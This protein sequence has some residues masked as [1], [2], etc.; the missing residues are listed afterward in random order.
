MGFSD[1]LQ[2]AAQTIWDF[3]LVSEPIEKAEAIFVFG[4][5]N[6]RV[7]AH[8][9]ALFNQGL[10]PLIL[11]SGNAP[12]LKKAIFSKPE[13]VVFTDALRQAGIAASS[14]LLETQATNTGENVR[15]GMEKLS[16]NGTVPTRLILISKPP[17]MLRCK[18]TFKRHFPDLKTF[19]SPSPG[20]ME[21]YLEMSR[22]NRPDEDPIKRLAEEI[23]RLVK[24]SE[25]GYI[26]KVEIPQS[27][28]EAAMRIKSLMA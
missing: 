21:I 22:Q 2:G 8:A 5:N 4:S 7:P 1:E 12:R 10:A 24:Y 23:E 3:L 9:V 26:E 18:A 19:A 6:M 16:E 25:L 14:I 27:V 20:E 11:V 15:F 17:H 28:M 13:A